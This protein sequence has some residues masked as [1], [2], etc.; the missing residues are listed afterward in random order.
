M[1]SGQEFT[2]E[3]IVDDA[4]STGVPHGAE[5]VAFASTVLGNDAAELDRA[6]E[7]LNSAAGAEAVTAAALT[8]AMFSMVDRAAN[9]IGIW[10][11]PMVLEPSAGFREALGINRFPSAANTLARQGAG[12]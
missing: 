1:K 2:L 12:A 6:R 7:A 4:T 10:V 3:G 11:E 9:G 5:L 8:A